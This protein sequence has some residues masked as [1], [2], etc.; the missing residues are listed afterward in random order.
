MGAP[1]SDSNRLV[2]HWFFESLAI[3]Q[4]V[5]KKKSIFFKVQ[6]KLKF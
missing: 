2:Q 4:N 6:L 3:I 1:K 5:L